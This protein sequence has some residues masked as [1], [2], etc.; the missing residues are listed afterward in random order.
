MSCLNINLNNLLLYQTIK[1]VVVVVVVVVLKPTLILPKQHANH[2]VC[3]HW[4]LLDWQVQIRCFCG[5]LQGEG[6]IIR[7]QFDGSSRAEAIKE[8]SSA[9]ERL[10]EHMPVTIQHDIP[11]PPNQST[12]EVSEPVLQVGLFTVQQTQILYPNQ[13]AEI[14]RL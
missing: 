1:F 4:D 10:M 6:R 3:F 5:F 14:R 2:R 7:M 13:S 8:C 11:Q 9:L 12:A